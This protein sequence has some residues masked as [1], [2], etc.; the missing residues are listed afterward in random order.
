MKHNRRDKWRDNDWCQASQRARFWSILASRV[1]LSMPCVKI[2]ITLRENRPSHRPSL[3]L[4][5]SREVARC[6]NWCCSAL[7]TL[8]FERACPSHTHRTTLFTILLPLLFFF[9]NTISL[10]LF[11][12][13]TCCFDRAGILVRPCTANCSNTERPEFASG[14]ATAAKDIIC[15]SCC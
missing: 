4:S 14:L 7:A 8:R 15:Y 11:A 3:A 13:P 12:Q 10:E 9:L 2:Q 6:R 5:L 1:D